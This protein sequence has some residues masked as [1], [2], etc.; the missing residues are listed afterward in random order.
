MTSGRSSAD[1][2]MGSPPSCRGAATKED[3]ALALR[4][5]PSCVPCLPCLPGAL[6]ATDAGPRAPGGK[7]GGGRGV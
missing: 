6:A 4:T 5:T 7:E 1:C 3:D 2:S